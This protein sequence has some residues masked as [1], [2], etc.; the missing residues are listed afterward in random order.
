MLLLQSAPQF[1]SPSRGAAQAYFDFVEGRPALFSVMCND[2]LLTGYGVLRDA[3]ERM[4]QAY[5]AAIMKD[6]RVPERHRQN[7]A[8]ALC[9]LGRGMAAIRAAYPSGV[10]PPDLARVLRDAEQ[11]TKDHTGLHVNLAV[12]YGGR[13]E[14]VDAVLLNAREALGRRMAETGSV[15]K[16]LDGVAEVFGLSQRPER[17]EVYDNSHIQ[18]TNA[19]GAMIVAAS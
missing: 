4:F 1:Q 8:F 5:E 9:A 18:G 6:D 12:G 15:A 14:I 10:L 11:R 17:I 7:V 13:G 2:R 3:Q 16:L 19:L